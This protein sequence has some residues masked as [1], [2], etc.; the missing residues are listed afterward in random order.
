MHLQPD[1]LVRSIELLPTHSGF[2]CSESLLLA[3]SPPTATICYKSEVLPAS[4]LISGTRSL[5]YGVLQRSS[6][7]FG[8]FDLLSHSHLCG[9]GTWVQ[10]WRLLGACHYMLQGLCAVFCESPLHV[11][12]V[13]LH[14]LSMSV[15]PLYFSIGFWVRV[16]GSA[17]LE[18][19]LELFCCLTNLSSSL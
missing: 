19:T 15:P 18:R 12:S 16:H 8:Q 2:N 5:S 4:G 17:L 9:F 7:C 10:S 3:D 14:R 1:C 11:W 6:S 13:V